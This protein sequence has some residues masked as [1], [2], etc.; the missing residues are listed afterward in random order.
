MRGS[1]RIAVLATTLATAAAF[2]YLAF[3]LFGPTYTRCSI[4]AAPG[5]PASAPVCQSVGWLALQLAEPHP[6]GPD[7]RPAAFLAVWTAAPLAA[8]IATRVLRG[9]AAAGVVSLALLIELTSAMSM[10]GGFVYAIV[11]GPLL[12]VALVGSLIGSRPIALT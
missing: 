3:F 11:C 8:L 7:L 1:T 5:Q 12:L 9:G 4:S 10:G 2:A 6:A